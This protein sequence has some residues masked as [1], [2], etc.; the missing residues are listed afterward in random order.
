M[1]GGSATRA[2]EPSGLLAGGGGKGELIQTQWVPQR[3]CEADF[4]RKRVL[5]RYAGK[6]QSAVLRELYLVADHQVAGLNQF[7]QEVLE[8]SDITQLQVVMHMRS[9]W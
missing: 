5:L 9:Q 6:A 4:P 1:G 2:R 3:H 7:V 8:H